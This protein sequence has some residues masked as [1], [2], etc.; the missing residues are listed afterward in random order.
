MHASRL[1]ASSAARAEA[2][3]VP[4]VVAVGVVGVVAPAPARSLDGAGA[5]D[6]TLA[7][8]VFTAGLAVDAAVVGRART[9]GARL[10]L[11]VA[12]SA[13]ALPAL[14]WA[15]AHLVSGPARGGV[16]ALGVAPTEVASLG[17]VAMAGGEVALAAALLVASSV[18][19]VL[20]G[21]PVLAGLSGAQGVHAGGLLVT[22]GLVVALPLACGASARHVLAA[23]RALLDAG[24]L[25]GLAALLLLLWEVAGEVQL[26]ASYL[27][28]V[29]A[30][31][32]FLA[33]AWALGWLLARRASAA[34]RP[35]VH[36]CVSMRDF[37][38]A[39]GIAASAFGPRA[40]AP[41]GVYGVFV[42]LAGA[43][44]ARLARRRDPDPSAPCGA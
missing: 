13:V 24:R 7:V 34:V 18:V 4:L 21:G 25:V 14:A 5:V 31:A 30:L 38:V 11:V 10:A 26:R 3:L 43:V 37:A 35:A 28:V 12:V 9:Q 1:L 29:A 33:G 36:L 39:A 44:F 40:V 2:W 20:A 15:L 17:L 32:C 16:L 19:T 41:L 27:V 42:I 8:L 6:P 22:L 23:P